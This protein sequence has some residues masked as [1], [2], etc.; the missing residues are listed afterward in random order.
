MDMIPANRKPRLS[1]TATKTTFA[2][3]AGLTLVGTL[4]GCSAAADAESGSGA[5][6]QGT[7]SSAAP[8]AS[9]TTDASASS[10]SASY[11]DGSYTAKGSYQSPGGEEDL[12][13][14]VTLTKDVVTALDVVSGANSP[15]G[16]QFQ[17]KFI[18]GIQSEVV[19]KDIDSLKVSKVAGSSLTSGGFNEAIDEIKADAAAS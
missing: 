12:T 10:G 19:G 14:T 8:S 11:K 17:A 5:A 7:S 3:L 15:N 13:V 9:S 16:K 4:A 1:R 2:A 6:P 18:S